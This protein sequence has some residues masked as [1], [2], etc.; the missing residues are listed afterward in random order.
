MRV[1][2]SKSLTNRALVVAA[3]AEGPSI[4]RGALDCEDTQVMVAASKAIGIAVEHDAAS[5][6]DQG[7]GLLGAIPS[8]SASLYLAN[9]GT[10]LRFLDGHAG[11]RDGNLSPGR[12][13]AH[14]AAPDF[15]TC[16]SRST[17]WGPARRPTWVR[18]ARR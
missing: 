3:L 14:A 12:H 7:S 6:H 5:G 15:A 16:S 17:A 10:S 8:R 2:G 1:P 13:A 18:A 4:L 9:S 11:H